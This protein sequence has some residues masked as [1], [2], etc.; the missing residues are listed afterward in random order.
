M[1]K[2]LSLVALLTVSTSAV[3]GFTASNNTAAPKSTVAQ[4]LKIKQD[5]APIQLSGKIIRQVDD[6][7]F[8]FRD[9]TGEIKIDVEEGAWQGIDVTPN[10]TITIFG[11]VDHERFEPNTIDVFRI[12][13]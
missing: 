7:E 12:Q 2:L 6:D 11:Q 5:N 9:S 13:K 8:I 1:K 10:E 4:A 3:A